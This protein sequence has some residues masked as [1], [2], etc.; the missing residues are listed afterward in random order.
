MKKE[1]Q[2]IVL[3]GLKNTIKLPGGSGGGNNEG[4]GSG[5]GDSDNSRN[6]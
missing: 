6:L 1:N 4:E 2:T 3:N 5:D